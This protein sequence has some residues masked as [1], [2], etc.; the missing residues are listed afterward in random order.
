[1]ATKSTASSLRVLFDHR[2]RRYTENE[3]VS[4]SKEME[5]DLLISLSQVLREIQRWTSE[6]GSDSAMASSS[7]TG[8]QLEDDE[9]SP[10]A[11]S[12]SELEYSCLVDVVADFV[13]LLGMK[14]PYIQH[15]S[16]SILVEVSEFLV[17]CGRQWDVFI[18]TLC[19]CVHSVYKFQCPDLTSAIDFN[20]SNSLDVLKHK[21]KNT[22]RYMGFGIFRVLRN[23][24]KRLNGEENYE[25]LGVFYKSI[26]SV[27]ASFPHGLLDKLHGD[28]EINSR[29][30]AQPLGNVTGHD[31]QLVF[32]GEFVQF[33]CSLIRQCSFL[34]DSSS[35][36][37]TNLILPKIIDL[38]P[39]LLQWCHPE[40][41]NQIDTCMSR[42]LMHKLLV[43]MI[44][45]SYLSELNCTTLHSWLQYLH[46][47]YQ[48]FLQQPISRHGPVQDNCLD[49]SPFLSSLS[50]GEIRK[51]YS[52]HLQR[53]A[54]FLFLRCSFTLISS[55]K[56]FDDR[57]ER[58]CRK[59]GLKEI[60]EWIE[61]QIP[62]YTFSIQGTCFEK[63][64]D[65]SISFIRLYMHE[66][67]LLFKVLLQLLS[68]PLHGEKLFSEEKISLRDEE[69][70]II[71]SL[72]ILF[73]PLSLF[74]IF[75][76]ELHYDHQVLLDYLISRDTGTSCA[77]YLLRC[78]RVVCNSWN[79]FLE[80]RLAEK[81]ATDESSS[82]KRKTLQESS[83]IE[84]AKE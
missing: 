10:A 63:N 73:N 6:A 36:G 81:K 44:R 22:D 21:L 83:K 7:E 56:H 72:S 35:S 58:D 25:L 52:D 30:H 62:G 17:E 32:L 51:I 38:V 43:L 4:L 55:R 18:R 76:S 66:D 11:L 31:Q 74:C 54:V 64:M 59:K 47:H 8:E 28:G 84:D 24:L 29:A 34:E 23:I 39:D 12:I 42:Y 68:V 37:P 65:F 14:S 2:L 1:M 13:G 33:L 48:G 77:E 69:Q 27:L 57:C 40:L 80:Y 67:D 60:H 71:F 19:D 20:L 75:L 82:K 61:E 79:I 5:K 3:G 50:N 26:S 15:L 46:L 49:S 53:L 78:L 9:E 41:E 45:L 70:T 16:V